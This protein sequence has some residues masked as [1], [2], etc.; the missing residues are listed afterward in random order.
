MHVH[1]AFRLTVAGAVAAAFAFAQP[2]AAQPQQSLKIGF[3]TT[4]SGPLG[5]IGKHMRVA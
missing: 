5:V 2:A 1:K 4:L 3:I